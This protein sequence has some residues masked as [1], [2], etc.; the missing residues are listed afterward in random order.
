MIYATKM[1]KLVPANA[2]IATRV[3]ATVAEK[4]ILSTDMMIII[5][6]MK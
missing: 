2:V 6:V 5:I 4:T 3:T 1:N